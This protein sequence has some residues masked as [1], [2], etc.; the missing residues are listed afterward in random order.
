MSH[1]ARKLQFRNSETEHIWM[2]Y[3]NACSYVLFCQTFCPTEGCIFASYICSQTISY[4][5]CNQLATYM[6]LIVQ[7]CASSSY[8]VTMVPLKGSVA[9]AYFLLRTQHSSG[10]SNS[11]QL[12]YI[13]LATSAVCSM[14]TTLKHR[15]WKCSILHKLPQ[16][17]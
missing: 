4:T 8:Q 16:V 13:N 11:Q 10:S 15:A 6:Q 7:N 9:L 1:I 5:P 14:I 12:T 17:A 3:N 2:Q